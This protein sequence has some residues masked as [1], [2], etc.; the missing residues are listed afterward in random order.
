[1]S[2]INAPLEAIPRS[3]TH[4]TRCNTIPGW[5]SETDIERETSLFWHS[6]WTINGKP[7]VGILAYVMRYVR[8]HY[9]SLVRKLQKYRNSA[10]KLSLGVALTT[11]Q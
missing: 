1:M 11:H 7:D 10:I 2:C 6:L 5:N 3:T 8:N 9:H 4:S